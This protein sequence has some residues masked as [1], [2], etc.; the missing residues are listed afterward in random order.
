[1]VFGNWYSITNHNR[2]IPT[3]YFLCVRVVE[4]KKKTEAEERLPLLWM[5]SNANLNKSH[6]KACLLRSSQWSA[7]GRDENLRLW[8]S[9]CHMSCPLVSRLAVDT[10][11]LKSSGRKDAFLFIN[12][13]FF[14]FDCQRRYGQLLWTSS[15]HQAATLSPGS[16]H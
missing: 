6:Y 14:R 8:R 3:V 11:S 5:I 4:S 16:I 1:M 9:R 12:C 13:W 15:H 2:F 7:S 10:D